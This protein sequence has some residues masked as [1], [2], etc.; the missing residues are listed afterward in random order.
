VEK[1]GSQ[2]FPEI[3]SQYTFSICN[4]QRWGL[5]CKGLIFVARSTKCCGN[6]KWCSVNDM[7]N[8]A[9]YWATGQDYLM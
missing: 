9:V 2:E 3:F 4:V 1:L 8:W 5:R 6:D 7:E